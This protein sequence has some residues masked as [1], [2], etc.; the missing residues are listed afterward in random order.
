M[1]Q[2]FPI[3][4]TERTISGRGPSVR[5]AL[6]VRT[7]G[8][9]V[10]EAISGLGGV[11]V[12][13]ALRFDLLQAD[14]QLTRA[15]GL[16][17]DRITRFGI[18]LQSNLDPDTY[19]KQY[20]GV[21]QEINSF[22]PK[23]RR[24]SRA[25]AQWL[26]DEKPNWLVDV[27]KARQLRI[28][29]NWIIQDFEELQKAKQNGDFST[30]R[31]RVTKGTIGGIYT[32]VEGE[33]RLNDAQRA[34][35]AKRTDIVLEGAMLL[36][37]EKGD[38]KLDSANDFIDASD[39][40][41]TEKIE[42][43]NVVDLQKKHEQ[44]QK[45]REQKEL[46]EQ[47]E[48]EILVNIYDGEMRAKDIRTLIKNALI[49]DERGLT[50]LGPDQ[51]KSLIVALNSSTEDIVTPL[52]TQIRME[53]LISD[54]KKGDKTKGQANSRLIKLAPEINAA[55]AKGY[56]K[57]IS[58]AAEDAKSIE[59]RRM[60]DMLTLRKKQLRDAIEQVD[61]FGIK[62]NTELLRDLA[63]TAV[64]ELSDRFD[65]GD[66]TDEEVKNEVDRLMNKFTLSGE[67]L[68]R[69]SSARDLRLAENLVQQQEAIT[70]IVASLRKEGRTDEA[71]A[72]MDEYIALGV[73]EAEGETI[74]K[75]KGKKVGL[76]K[77]ALERI[78]DVIR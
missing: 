67:Q 62:M 46:R 42:L 52:G 38:I 50:K 4:R 66:F 27:E 18:E 17:N 45:D 58:D 15:K 78:L 71:K 35:K 30:Y 3:I 56:I 65:E 77:G 43:K 51:A 57:R 14:N 31:I 34:E 36:R 20:A 70:K 76:G 37:D 48:A 29:D 32:P 44:Q 73:F 60:N 55:D 69:A 63:N 72:I 47:T 16:A 23:N 24:A 25:Y 11:T 41:A 28:K 64:I 6:D 61:V 68:L 7:G 26:L 8:R 33:R 75:K 9:E 10:A 1:A 5:A 39:L 49:P 59:R 2:K 74:K 19:H 13:E 54:V 21:L 40:S 12:Q 22:T 53:A